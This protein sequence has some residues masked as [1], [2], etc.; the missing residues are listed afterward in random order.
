MLPKRPLGKVEVV[1]LIASARGSGALESE[2]IHL[3]MP[4]PDPETRISCLEMLGGGHL[5]PLL[6][7]DFG[8]YKEVSHHVL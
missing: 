6:F 4:L 1:Q 8:S 3:L 7:V 2:I 5:G